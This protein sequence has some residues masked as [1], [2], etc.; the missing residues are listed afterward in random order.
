MV[1]NSNQ[2]NNYDRSQ[3]ST[4]PAVFNREDNSPH[5]IS[6]T[7]GNDNLV[8]RSFLEWFRNEEFILVEMATCTLIGCC[9]K[10]LYTD[11]IVRNC[12]GGEKHERSAPALG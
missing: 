7:S 11:W 4:A 5:C 1:S 10:N 9:C 3:R 12:S 6:Y 2:N 8:D